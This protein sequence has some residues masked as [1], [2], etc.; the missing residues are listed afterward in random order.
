MDSTANHSGPL[1]L[2]VPAA[3]RLLGLHEETVRRLVRENR[4]PATKVGRSWRFNRLRIEAWAEGR[5][6]ERRPRRVLAVDDEP[7][8][9]ELVRATLAEIGCH[10]DVAQTAERAIV[11]LR[12]NPYDAA[13]LDLKLGQGSGVDVIREARRLSPEM[14]VVIVSGYPDSDL[15]QQ[16]MAHA[17]LLVLAKP[18]DPATLRGAVSGVFRGQSRL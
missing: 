18:V 17:P 6:G 13:L 16:A 10:V 5:D 8:I 4:I 9:G 11:L 3:A 2:D 14:A 7:M 1:Y 15:M 12:S